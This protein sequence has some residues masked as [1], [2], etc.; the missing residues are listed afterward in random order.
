MSEYTPQFGKCPM[1]HGAVEAYGLTEPQ[2]KNWCNK[3]CCPDCGK[4]L[5]EHMKRKEKTNGKKCRAGI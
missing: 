4:F 1:F 5:E 3:G 2:I